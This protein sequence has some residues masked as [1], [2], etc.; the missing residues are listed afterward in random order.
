MLLS[1][2]IKRKS[3]QKK[4]NAFMKM[5]CSLKFKTKWLKKGNL[6]YSFVLEYS[7]STTCYTNLKRP[8]CPIL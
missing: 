6:R 7:I 1:F 8:L 4:G 3:K 5:L 2:L